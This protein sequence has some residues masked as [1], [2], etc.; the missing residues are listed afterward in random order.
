M[1][2]YLSIILTG[3]IVI[4]VLVGLSALGLVE[5]DR[6]PESE[7]SPRR[8]SYN[9]GPTGTRALYQLL[10]G[11]GAR[12]A[13]WREG[14]QDLP[15]RASD[16][17]LILVGPFSEGQLPSKSETKA[18]QSF[19]ISGGRLLVVSRAPRAEFDDAAIHITSKAREEDW[20]ASSDDI[21]DAESEALIVQPTELTRGLKGLQLSRLA[22]RLRFEPP[23]P[24]PA[25][26]DDEDTAALTSP[27]VHLGDKDGAVVADFDYGE[28]RVVFLS[29]PFVI[30]NN[31]IARGANLTLVLNLIHTLG[32]NE[33]TILFDEA[34]HGYRRARN[35]L[36]SY[37][38]GTPVLWALVQ[39]LLLAFLVAYTYGRRF[40][41]PLPLPQIDRHS[42]LEF[43]GSMANLQ[44]VAAARD[45]ALENIF[46]RFRAQLC[47]ALGVSVRA[48]SFEIASTLSHRQ[49]RTPKS[50]EV[51]RDELNT[52]L[53]DSERAL[54][55][56]PISD[57]RLVTLVARMRQISGWLKGSTPR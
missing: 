40:A 28:G 5:F 12:V 2:R 34:H 7:S 38:R 1:R 37:F 18:L 13:R 44:Q 42:P 32:G 10:E 39:L 33:R 41:R 20:T 19:L 46:P 15:E 3:L 47:R 6:P 49:L 11:S 17:L 36:F 54:A 27:V 57:E 8:T 4:A 23:P 14:Y 16:S 35:P 56:E 25:P 24:A 55:G 21:V 51:T 31:G 45:L 53:R 29:D 48:D 43:V 26:T 9:P 22:A 30:A 50:H 52:L